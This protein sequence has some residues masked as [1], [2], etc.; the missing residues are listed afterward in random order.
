[1]EIDKTKEEEIRKTYELGSEDVKEALKSLFPEIVKSKFPCYA[2]GMSSG[3]LYLF[4]SEYDC[5]CIK[6]NDN[7][8]LGWIGGLTYSHHIP[9]KDITEIL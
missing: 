4:T 6:G 8:G 7:V 3:A 1:M 5:I 2:K 9:V